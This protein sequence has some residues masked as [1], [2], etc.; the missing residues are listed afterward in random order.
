MK[1]LKRKILYRIN[2]YEIKGGEKMSRKLYRE[3]DKETGELI[4]LECSKCREIKTADCFSKNKRN[5]RLQ[6]NRCYSWRCSCRSK[7]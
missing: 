3:Y 5:K 2:K 6:K 7:A 1:L 4:K